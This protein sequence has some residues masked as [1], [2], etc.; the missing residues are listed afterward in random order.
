MSRDADNSAGC[1]TRLIRMVL[2]GGLALI[3]V[4]AVPVGL[5]AVDFNRFQQQPVLTEGETEQLNIPQGTSWQGVVERV[6][7]AGLVDNGLYFDLWGRHTGLDHEVKA[8]AF[9]LEG[10]MELEE[11]AALLREGGRADE[12]VVT[13]RE[14]LTKFDVADRLVDAELVQRQAFLEVVDN[15]QYLEGADDELDS[16]EGYLFP[17]TYHFAT[18]ASEHEIVE[19]MLRQFEQAA[20]PVFDRHRDEMQH[21]REDYG[22]D[23]H[24]IVTL[25][26]LVERETSVDDERPVVARVFYNRLDEGMLLQTDPTCVYGEDTYDQVP[27]PELCNDPYNR[28]STYVIEGLPPGPIASPSIASLQAALAPAEGPDAREYLYFVSRRDGTGRHHFTTNYADHR[29]AIEEYLVGE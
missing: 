5:I 23:R 9:Y 22:F 4:A 15:P 8:G 28:Y 1:I 7:D 2:L 3:V 29:D 21:I 10:P 25:A 16:L 26:S 19:R 27:T 13:L 18:D 6:A 17:E 14:G 20:Q 11:L 12:V 24:D